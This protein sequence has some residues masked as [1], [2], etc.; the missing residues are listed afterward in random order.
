MGKSGLDGSSN[1]PVE[2]T[3]PLISSDSSTDSH[4]M[5]SRLTTLSR[6]A[7]LVCRVCSVVLQR[8]W[9]F[10]SSASL[11]LLLAFWFYGGLVTLALLHV[12]VLGN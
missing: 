4:N 7:R 2:Q 1:D 9:L 10:C 5:A 6:I 11:F 12:A 8:F 3:I